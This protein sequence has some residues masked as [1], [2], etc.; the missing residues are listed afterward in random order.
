MWWCFLYHKPKPFYH[1]AVLGAAG[2]YINSGG[3]NAAVAQNIRQF[4]DIPLS[5]V[6]GACKQLAEIM[7]KYF[8]WLHT[9]HR[10]QTFHLRPYIASVQWPA[11]ARCKDYAG[12]DPIFSCISQQH[13]PQLAGDKYGSSL[14]FA[15]HA[16]LT[17][18]NCLYRKIFQLGHTDARAAYGLQQKIELLAL[19]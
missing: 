18:Q 7:G 15:L 2:H 4:C 19:F 10:A 9:G 11:A 5:T 16:Y 12:F 1:S 3:V 13:F 17:A 6:K 14:A 8:G